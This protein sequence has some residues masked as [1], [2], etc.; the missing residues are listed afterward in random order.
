MLSRRSVATLTVIGRG[1]Y[2]L[3]RISAVSFFLLAMPLVLTATTTTSS[4]A[5]T[6]QTMFDWQS[7]VAP[8]HAVLLHFPFGFLIAACLLELVYWRNPRPV[9]RD[10]MVWLMPLNLVC[11]IIVTILGLFLASGGDYNAALTTSHRNYGFA[12]TATTMMATAALAMERRGKVRRWTTM[13]R[14]LLGLSFGVLLGAGHSGGNLTHG[15]TFLTKNAPDFLRELIQDANQ[16]SNS[17]MGESTGENSEKDNLFALKVE[18]ILRKRCLKCHGPEKQ[19]GDYRVDD[20]KL[21]F[22]GGESEETAVVPGNPGDSNL[23][24]GIILPEDDDDVMP[25]EGKG[26]LSDEETLTLIK[27]IQSGALIGGQTTDAK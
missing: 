4:N 3:V 26:H 5:V 2:P 7:F 9:L 24:R 21:L 1:W 10:V 22:A 27:W 12:T 6:D 8:F 15:T 13:F 17:K 20:M 18:P 16:G 11:L 25:P 19:K 14:V 23:I